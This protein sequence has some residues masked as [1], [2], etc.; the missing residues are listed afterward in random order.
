MGVSIGMVVH[1]YLWQRPLA[2]QAFR[3]RNHLSGIIHTWLLIGAKR[4]CS[5][6]ADHVIRTRSRLGRKWVSN[7]SSK[8]F[9]PDGHSNPSQNTLSISSD[10]MNLWSRIHVS[11]ESFALIS[12]SLSLPLTPA[13]SLRAIRR[14][15]YFVC[16]FFF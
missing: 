12:R 16:S 11:N 4:R 9:E 10:K 14:F 13:R 2:L 6:H 8:A 3:K 7:H 1:P 5:G 15:R